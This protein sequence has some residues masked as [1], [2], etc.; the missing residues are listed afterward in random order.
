MRECSASVPPQVG[1]ILQ[2]RSQKIKRNI[3]KM[4]TLF[5]R[6]IPAGFCGLFGDCA[7][8][9]RGELIGAGLAAFQSAESAKCYG[10]GDFFRLLVLSPPGNGCS[11]RHWGRLAP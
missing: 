7:P 1:G 2:T 4:I 6:L 11:L 9:L 8:L 5:F 3:T 10:G